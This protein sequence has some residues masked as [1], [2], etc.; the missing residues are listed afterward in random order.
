MSSVR[1]IVFWCFILCVASLVRAEEHPDFTQ[2]SALYQHGKGAPA[3]FPKAFHYFMKAAKDNH[4]RSQFYV[5]RMYHLEA[6]VGI[7]L[8]AAKKW[9]RLAGEN[10]DANAWHNL[11]NVYR[12]S[13]GPNHIVVECFNKGAELGVDM[14]H[15]ALGLAYRKGL[16]GLPIDTSK[17]VYHYEKAAEL[18][19]PQSAYLAAIIYF[20]GENAVKAD[21]VK[22][23]Y[24][25]SLGAKMGDDWS[26]HWLG[27]LLDNSEVKKHYD[28]AS[29]Q[30]WGTLHEN[31]K[32]KVNH[33]VQSTL[34]ET[35]DAFDE[36]G[37][38]AAHPILADAMNRWQENNNYLSDYTDAIWNEAQLKGGRYNFLWS[39]FLYERVCDY[40]RKKKGFTSLLHTK[41]NLNDGYVTLGQFG[42]LRQSLEEVKHLIF[43][44]ETIDV[45]ATVS[46][47]KVGPDYQVLDAEKLPVF[48][49]QK[50]GEPGTSGEFIG[51]GAMRSLE[52]LAIERL[53]VGDWES[54]LIIAE[55]MQRWSDA[56]RK[57]GVKPARSYPDFEGEF[58][59]LP[60]AI[61]I[62]AFSALGLPEQE[63]EAAKYIVELNADSYGGARLHAA[64]LWL[65]D[66]AVTQG[67]SHEISLK[68]LEELEE[69][70]RRNIYVGS[71]F[72]KFAKLVRAK[73]IAKTGGLDEGLPL[74]WEVLEETNDEVIVSLRLEALMTAAQLSLEANVTAG[75]DKLLSEALE[76]A[77][78]RGLL[79]KEIKIYEYYVAY[80]LATHQYD[81]A[82]EMQSRVID[83]I[84]ALKLT[85]RLKGALS[86]IDEIVSLQKKHL[87]SLANQGSAG[88]ESITRQSGTTPDGHNKNRNDGPQP[89]GKTR[90]LLTLQPKGISTLPIG[91][92]I[93]AVFLL[94][95][96]SPISTK[97]TLKIQSDQFHITR[98]EPQE[99]GQVTVVCRQQGGGEVQALDCQA[100]VSGGTQLPIVLIAEGISSMAEAAVSISLSG[101]SVTAQESTWLIQPKA[102]AGVIAVLD[103]ARLTDSNFSLVPV[104]HQLASSKTG[105]KAALRIIASEPTRVEGFA[106]DGT[107]LFIDAEGNGSFAD[108]G[109]LIATEE[110]DN[111][112]PVLKSGMESGKFALRYRPHAK[113]QTQQMEV[114]IETRELGEDDA[115]SLDAVDLLE[116]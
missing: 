3:D 36:G 8:E 59:Q 2:G 73:V 50:L 9:Y 105:R 108:A 49:K 41:A 64:Q 23:A 31:Y 11:G 107:L 15:H 45:D 42:L 21:K 48:M 54:A 43:Q 12:Q 10:G 75:V 24:Y 35:R 68:E 47:V 69:N 93:S 76:S 61:R 40:Q 80:L 57:A 4:S 13:G 84:K 101:D 74:V 72:W 77:R 16:Y 71:H 115:W 92:E 106:A 46:G 86:R 51:V 38:K 81:A 28:A 78:S 33:E 98:D 113:L 63:A 44:V 26:A 99:R 91:N 53:A 114:R 83:L 30:E 70:I 95:N 27:A 55:W 20:R 104:F 6:S 5:G 94:S 109:D 97:A 62:S 110:M 116:P 88:N 17:A 37:S 14:S 103:A 66:L 32:K 65:F 90:P 112:N 19:E 67:R 1:A 87:A 52:L 85:P 29:L 100:E 34:V 25:F 39:Q 22:A 102:E 60:M 96:L 111:L 18:N 58:A 79:M 7:D 89:T 56:F 82:L